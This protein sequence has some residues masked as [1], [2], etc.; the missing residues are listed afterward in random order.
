MRL[1]E[2]SNS[3]AE[4]EG[5]EEEEREEKERRKGGERELHTRKTL[6]HLANIST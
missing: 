3:H 2:G 6:C 5:E 4:E 1:G